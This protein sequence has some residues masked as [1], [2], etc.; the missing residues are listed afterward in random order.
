VHDNK[1]IIDSIKNTINDI[2]YDKKRLNK[3][4]ESI[5]KGDVTIDINDRLI[6]NLNNLEI[7]DDVIETA[8]EYLT[9]I[10][11]NLESQKINSTKNVTN[12]M[13]VILTHVLNGVRNLEHCALQLTNEIEEH[14]IKLLEYKENNNVVIKEPTKDNIKKESNKS[15]MLKSFLPNNKISNIVVWLMGFILFLVILFKID[16]IATSKSLESTS[17][18]LHNIKG[19]ENVTKNR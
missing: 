1:I 14:K 8:F 6:N 4:I 5:N 16:N 2:S 7:E 10:L 19:K 3:I 11:S 18:L 13:V 12:E 17:K 9:L 15:D